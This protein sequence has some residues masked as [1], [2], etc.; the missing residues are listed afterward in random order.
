MSVWFRP[1]A[2]YLSAADVDALVEPAI[3]GGVMPGVHRA[4]RFNWHRDLFLQ[5]RRLLGVDVS[6]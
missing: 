2:E 3:K 6:A 1:I 4:A 5:T